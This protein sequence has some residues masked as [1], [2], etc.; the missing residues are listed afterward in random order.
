MRWADCR[1]RAGDEEVAAPTAVLALPV[2]FISV[3][4]WVVALAACCLGDQ[5]TLRCFCDFFFFVED[6]IFG[7][8]METEAVSVVGGACIRQLCMMGQREFRLDETIL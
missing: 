6:S 3:K 4:V 5:G 7:R 1:T 8:V 2:S